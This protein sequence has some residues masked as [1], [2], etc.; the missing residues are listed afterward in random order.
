MPA[1]PGSVDDAIPGTAQ[2]CEIQVSEQAPGATVAP[3]SA[4]TTHYLHLTLDGTSMP[5]TSQAFNNH[6][7]LDPQLD[8]ALALTKTSPLR[9]VT[10]GQLVPYVLTLNNVAGTLLTDV[11]LIDR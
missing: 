1:C 7:P 10:R 8:G 6:I 9:E 4:G 11:S 5:G 3:R 2:Y